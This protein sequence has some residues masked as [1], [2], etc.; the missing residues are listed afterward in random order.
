M[1]TR[2]PGEYGNDNVNNGVGNTGA[3]NNTPYGGYE[4]YGNTGNTTPGYGAAGT[5]DQLGGYGNY[6]ETQPAAGAPVTGETNGL[7]IASLVIGIIALLGLVVG[8]LGFFVGII[9]LVV[10]ILAV[11][12]ARKIVGPGRR[13]GMSVAGLV[14][15]ILAIVLPLVLFGFAMAF[16]GSTGAMDCLS[17]GDQ[18]AMQTCIEDALAQ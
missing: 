2:E 7:A 15:S 14:L 3:G 9:G 12:K 10:G 4:N 5:N 11:V 17:L 13:M 16:L 6:A 8:G 18:A 1:T